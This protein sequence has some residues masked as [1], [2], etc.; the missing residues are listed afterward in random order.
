MDSVFKLTL[1]R[2]ALTWFRDHSTEWKFE[3]ENVV[4]VRE[5]QYLQTV[6]SFHLAHEDGQR[7]LLAFVQMSTLYLKKMCAVFEEF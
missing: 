2:T 6:I 3:P 1:T 4:D 7:F 5:F